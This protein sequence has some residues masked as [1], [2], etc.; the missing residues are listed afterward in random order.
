MRAAILLQGDPRFCSEFDL[1]LTNLHGYDEVDWFMYMWKDSPPTANL[2]AGTGHQ[3]VAPAWQH[4]DK[5]WALNKFKEL[6]PKNHK[7][8][9]LELADQNSVKTFPITEN[10]AQETIQ[11]N[12]WKMWYSQ[13]MANQLK[14]QHEKENNFT[15]DVVIRTRPDVS[16]SD[17]LDLQYVFEQ[18][19][20]EGNTVIIPQ[21]KRCGYGVYICDLFGISTSANMNVYS[22]LYNQALD[23]HSRGVIFHPETMLA[24]H[25]E[26]NNL[27][28]TTLGFNIEFRNHGIWKDITTGETW[29]SNIVPGWENKI[30]ISDF[31]R[32]A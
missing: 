19:K 4:V 16:L 10:F 11:S 5:D 24:R 27:R 32:W 13:Y 31:G 17:K 1:F 3:V 28:Y 26:F 12:V 7:I 29:S 6:L 8:I 18:L 23:H 22:D 20:L 2:L 14:I 15:Y 25:L 21:N 30:Y 9:S